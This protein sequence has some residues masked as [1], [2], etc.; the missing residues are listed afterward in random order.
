MQTGGTAGTTLYVSSSTATNSVAVL[1]ISAAALTSGSVVRITPGSG[2]LTTGGK[3]VEIVHGSAVAG[4]GLTVTT[5]GAYTGTGLVLLTAGAMTTGILC[6]LVS[7]TG[8]TSGSLLRATTSTA[9]AIATNGAISFSATG[10]YTS[11]SNCGFVNITANAT[12]AGTVLAISATGLV[13]GYGIYM[14]SAEAGLTT[15]NYMNLGAGKFTV[16][17]Y[18]AT[19]IAG[20]ASGTAALTLTAGDLTITSGF[21][22]ISANAKGV[23]FTGTGAN[24]GVLKNLKNAAASALSGTQKDI[25]ID[26]GGVPYYFTVY[27]TKA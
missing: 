20:N 25:E 6:S 4:N 19:V 13:D 11:T 7:T 18:G 23:T 10:I 16:S 1:D 21:L 12:T 24:G 14:A 2:T 9:G 27:P 17:K 3:S 22:V 26:I 5:T 15:G 8:L